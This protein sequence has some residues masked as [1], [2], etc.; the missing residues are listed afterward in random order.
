[1]LLHSASKCLVS[2]RAKHEMPLLHFQ[3]DRNGMPSNGSGGKHEKSLR[4]LV[5]CSKLKTSKPDFRY[6][7]V[8]L[9]TS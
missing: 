9:V 8:L 7:F 2:V 3:D 1:M 4:R 6:A 5:R